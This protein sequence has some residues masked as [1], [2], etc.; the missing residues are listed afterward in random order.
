MIEFEYWQLLFFPLFFGLGWAAAHGQM[1]FLHV[2]RL[3]RSRG[4]LS[5]IPKTLKF[6]GMPTRSIGNFIRY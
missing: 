2:M 5:P 1:W 3:F 6:T 4:R